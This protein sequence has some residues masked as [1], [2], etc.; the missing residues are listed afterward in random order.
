MIE[1]GLLSDYLPPLAGTPGDMVVYVMQGEAEGG[2]AVILGGTH[3]NE[4]AGIMAAV[5]LVEHAQVKQG[6]LFIIPHANNSAITAK[7]PSQPGPPDIVFHSADGERRFLYGARLT[8]PNHQEPVTGAR[9]G[10]DD[11]RNLNRV[12]PG[13]SDGLLTEQI[14]YAM[15]RL[16]VAEDAVIGID[17]HEAGPESRLA[18]LIVSH[19]N[20]L[21]VAAYALFDLELRSISLGLER[22]NPTNRGLS[23]FEWGEAT[24]AYSFLTETPNPGQGPA[25]HD[26]VVHDPRYPLWHRV[27]VQLAAIDALLR[28]YAEFVPNASP[29]VIEG[30]LELDD[31]ALHGLEAYLQ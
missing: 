22:S 16:F 3:G 28:S 13:R 14:A 17:L 2:S 27:G 15:N 9:M 19:P 12:H 26:N 31:L 11:A 23:H 5:V 10:T 29:V 21:D 18:N 24:P 4:I 6:T 8:H 7:L 25:A 30:I 20:A 1:V